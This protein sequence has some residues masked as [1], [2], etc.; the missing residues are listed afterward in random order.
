MSQIG[1][2]EGNVKGMVYT[3]TA[4]LISVAIFLFKHAKLL[5]K[6]HFVEIKRKEVSQ[7]SF[8]VKPN[9]SN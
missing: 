9:I 5:N 4:S 3:R 7:M 1:H 6:S 8:K 2:A